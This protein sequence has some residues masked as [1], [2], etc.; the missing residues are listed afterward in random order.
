M[1]SMVVTS[2]SGADWPTRLPD[3]GGDVESVC[4]SAGWAWGYR[5]G[6]L[7]LEAPW[8]GYPPVALLVWWP[9]VETSRSRLG[10]GVGVASRAPLPLTVGS[11]S[12]ASETDVDVGVGGTGADVLVGLV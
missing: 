4:L 10:A 7:G 5:R 2:K 6:G 3:W 8:L 12:V 9:D 1:P 11:M